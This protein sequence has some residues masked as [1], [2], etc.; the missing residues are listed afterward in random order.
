M[1]GSVKIT[2][3]PT[4]LPIG[5]AEMKERLRVSDDAQDAT[6]TGMIKTAVAMIDGPDGYGVAMMSQ[7]WTLAR[8][9]FARVIDLPGDPV[10]SVSAVRYLDAAGDWQV[11]DAATYRLVKNQEPARLVLNTG[12]SWPACATGFGV[13]EVDYILGAA[14][15][16]SADPALV[17][18][19]ALLVGSYFENREAVVVGPSVA[20]LPLGVKHILNSRRRGVVA[21]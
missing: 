10:T 6:I 17:T 16:A 19:V 9:H 18:A 21:G 11:V 1:W 2:T 8:D 15:A 5:L 7:T 12:Q 13:V 14:D 20:E 4:A 3:K